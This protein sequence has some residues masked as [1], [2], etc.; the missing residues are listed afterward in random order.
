MILEGKQ[1]QT[2]NLS[3]LL[4]TVVLFNQE[5][6]QLPQNTN[7]AQCLT[8]KSQRKAAA[9]DEPIHLHLHAPL[10]LLVL[11]FIIIILQEASR[12]FLLKKG[13]SVYL[14]ARKRKLP[15][16][17]ALNSFYFSSCHCGEAEAALCQPNQAERMR[18]FA[19]D[20]VRGGGGSLRRDAV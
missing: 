6:L 18:R 12:L 2:L 13:R 16:C 11:L 20:R 5:S 10:I 15:R 19:G 17:F 8:T 1:R 9:L 7:E 4:N 3:L 14:K